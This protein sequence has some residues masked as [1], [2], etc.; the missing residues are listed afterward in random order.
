MSLGRRCWMLVRRLFF[1]WKEKKF[2]N[3]FCN[4]Q[5]VSFL[6]LTSCTVHCT[7]SV[8]YCICTGHNLTSFH[9]GSVVYLYT[10]VLALFTNKPNESTSIVQY[11]S[12]KR[13]HILHNIWLTKQGSQYQPASELTITQATIST[14]LYLKG[15]EMTKWIS[16]HVQEPKSEPNNN[17]RRQRWASGFQ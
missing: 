14:G 2:C 11:R 10:R 16:N 4:R 13:S 8:N 1:F 12:K 6:T 3:R 17:E 5:C 7:V 9:L 15:G